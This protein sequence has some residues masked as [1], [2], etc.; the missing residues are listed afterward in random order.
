MKI[1]RTLYFLFILF[2]GVCCSQVTLF[3]LDKNLDLK[4]C[5]LDTWRQKEGLPS[6][7]IDGL[8]QTSDGYLWLASRSGLVRFDGVGFQIYNSSNVPTLTRSMVRS[9]ALSPKQE[10]WIGTDGDGFGRFVDGKYLP[11]KVEGG[12]SG[13]SEQKALFFAADGS[14]WI[15]GR[16]GNPL[17]H[18]GTKKTAFF[19]DSS[20]GVNAIAQDSFGKIWVAGDSPALAFQKSDGSF[21]TITKKEGLKEGVVGTC[22]WADSDGSVWLGTSNDG[23]FHIQYGKI[24]QY[25]RAEGLLS[26]SVNAMRRDRGGNLWIGTQDGMYRFEQNKFTRY[27]NAEGLFAHKVGAV[28]EDREENLWVCND[29]YLH[30]FNNTKMTPIDLSNADGTRQTRAMCS[31]GDGSVWVA[32]THGVTRIKGRKQIHYTTSD[33]LPANGVSSICTALDNTVWVMTED[34][35]YAYFKESRFVSIPPH[36]SGWQVGADKNGLV[37]A[38]QNGQFFRYTNG[39]FHALKVSEKPQ[40]VFLFYRDSSGQLWCGSDKGLH[41]IGADRVECIQKGLPPEAHILGIMEGKL[42]GE[43]WLSTDK[44]LARYYMGRMQ[45]W[46]KEDGLPDNNLYQIQRDKSNNL[47]LGGNAGIFSV[48]ISDL[49]SSER[50]TVRYTLYN[51]L[52]GVRSYPITMGAIQTEDGRLWFKGETGLTVFDPLHLPFNDVAPSVHIEKIVLDKKEYTNQQSITLAPGKNNLEIHYTGISLA[53]PEGVQFRYRLLG[54]E[55]DWISAS[56]RRVVFYTNLPPGRYTFQIK[57]ANEDGVWSPPVTGTTFQLQPYYYQTWWFKSVGGLACIGSVF[58]VFRWRLKRLK[59]SN[60]ILEEH[61]ATRTGELAHSYQELKEMHYA[62]EEMNAELK[63]ANDEMIA[64]NNELAT[65]NCKLEKANHKLATL[66]TTDGLTGLDNHRTFQEKLRH[67]L[68]LATRMGW[69]LGLLLLD[70]DFFKQ[71]NDVYGH[72]AGDTVLRILGRLLK[73]NVRTIDHVA[74]Y[75]GEEFAIILPNTDTEAVSVIGERIRKVIAE[76]GFPNRAVT[77]SIG[78]A[79]LHENSMEPETFVEC[80]DMALYDSKR[81]GRN[82]LTLVEEQ[83]TTL[84]A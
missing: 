4:Q 61:V 50:R 56:T 41:K 54:Y 6:Q 2:A 32:T 59:L 82:R 63:A 34:G 11:Y 67:E 81:S 19:L 51:A 22:L 39:G 68:A 20:N 3:A 30:R 44:G 38:A 48:L 55:Q 12:K 26:H 49:L 21:Q 1:V 35:H 75:G 25:N 58:G 14:L 29:T 27:N 52:Q 66:A 15:G 28:L 40:Y 31:T 47:W 36:L 43:I 60:Q 37:V 42:Q 45:V 69:S 18:I 57:A 8:V 80:A 78:A 71:Y 17:T 62:L 74:R 53:L 46:N 79:V 10:L 24:R 83:P 5:R 70:V 65:A 9:V 13:W 23:V 77:L 64:S 72:P 73:E 16:G 84:A 33:G 7:S 76:Y